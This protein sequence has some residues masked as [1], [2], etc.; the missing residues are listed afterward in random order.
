MCSLNF[1]PAQTRPKFTAGISV[2]GAFPYPMFPRENKALSLGA[3]LRTVGS[4]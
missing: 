3:D 2:S 4:Y 1:P